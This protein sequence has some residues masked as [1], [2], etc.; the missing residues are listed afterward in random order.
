[1][2]YLVLRLPFD[3]SF[4]LIFLLLFESRIFTE[5]KIISWSLSPFKNAKKTLCRCNFDAGAVPHKTTDRRR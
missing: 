1:M 3:L 5:I 2:L 4:C